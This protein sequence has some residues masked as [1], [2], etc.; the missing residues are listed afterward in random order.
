MKRVL[1][2]VT[3]TIG[4]A[5]L[6]AAQENNAVPAYDGTHKV[7]G[8]IRF[9]G[10]DGMLSLVSLWEVGF[11]KAQHLAHYDTE[12][13][14][15]A[16]AIGGL[17]TK[18]CD[19]GLMPRNTWPIEKLAFH[20]VLGYDP[21]MILVATAPVG[22]QPDGG[23][24]GEVIYVN[25]DNPLTELSIK[26]LDGIFGGA[27][28][29]GWTSPMK[30]TSSHGRGAD[31]DIRNWGQLGLAG[32]WA[33]K[34]IHTY[35]FDLTVNGFSEGM[36]TLVFNGGDKWNPNYQEFVK[37]EPTVAG[38]SKV[39]S[40]QLAAVA[41]DRLGITYGAGMQ[42]AAGHPELKVIAIAGRNSGPYIT[43]SRRTYQDRTYPLLDSVYLYINRPP[44]AP[45]DP[46]IK[47][48]LLYVLSKEGQ[49]AVV[50]DDSFL[51]LPSKDVATERSKLQ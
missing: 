22:D 34:P 26:Q 4:L 46:I 50:Q 30:W 39:L 29:G 15:T 51:P 16:M 32:E 3:L 17:Y 9:C 7:A 1:V 8:I 10:A 21:T 12:L 33:D 49:Q 18:T 19:I 2:L 5:N 31:E 37:S 48:F 23:S 20:S 45:I 38:S 41:K 11:N 47:E 24:Q 13:Y 44:N 43:P 6:A 40:G 28:S 35:G 27:R 36:D 25:R 14:S 42:L